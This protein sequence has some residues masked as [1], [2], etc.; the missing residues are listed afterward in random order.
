MAKP[1]NDL[2]CGRVAVQMAR[3]IGA[4]PKRSNPDLAKAMVVDSV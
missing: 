1:E 3:L 2:T 4:N